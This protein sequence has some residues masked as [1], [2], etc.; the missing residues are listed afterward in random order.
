MHLFL[1]FTMTITIWENNTSYIHAFSISAIN[2]EDVFYLGH[3]FFSIRAI[4]YTFSIGL[5]LNIEH[6]VNSYIWKQPL[7]DLPWNMCSIKFAKLDTLDKD[8]KT[9]Q[10]QAR[11]TSSPYWC[12]IAAHHMFYKEFIKLILMLLAFKLK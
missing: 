10:W 12:K 1:F 9:F 3:N 5:C 6:S 2:Y 8:M 4:N 11:S 7:K